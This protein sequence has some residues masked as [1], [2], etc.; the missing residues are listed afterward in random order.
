MTRSI[1]MPSEITPDVARF[2]PVDVG[3]DTERKVLMAPLKSGRYA[4]RILLK[5]TLATE[6][7][8]LLSGNFGDKHSFGIRLD[9]DEDYTALEKMLDELPAEGLD[10]AWAPRGVFKNGVLYLKCPTDAKGKQFAFTTNVSKL[11][12]GKPNPQ[13][14]REMP[15]EVETELSAYFGMD[16]HM[17]GL[18]F[19]VKHV[20]FGSEVPDP[21]DEESGLEMKM[22]ASAP[23]PTTAAGASKL[24][25]ASARGGRTRTVSSSRRQI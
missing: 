12:P 9:R 20:E 6:G 2:D 1:V 7:V 25:Y 22:S 13:I 11:V 24:P 17:Y 8:T 10:D 15:I 21:D 4:T 19:R 16:D 14:F 23:Q 3:Q 5:G 18:S